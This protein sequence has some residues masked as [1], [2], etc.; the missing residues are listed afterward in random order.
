MHNLRTAVAA[1][2]GKEP[3]DPLVLAVL[4]PAQPT[5]DQA[6]DRARGN[7]LLVEEMLARASVLLDRCIRFKTSADDLSAAMIQNS[8]QY[9]YQTSLDEIDQ[10]EIS[11]ELHRVEQHKTEQ[12]L[13]GLTTA[14]SL[15]TEALEFLK[16]QKRVLDE[17]YHIALGAPALLRRLESGV[18]GALP[19]TEAQ[20][21]QYDEIA[22]KAE[23][24]EIEFRRSQCDID[25]RLS[26]AAREMERCEVQ[27]ATA[28]VAAETTRADHFERR[29]EALRKMLSARHTHSQGGGPLDFMA[30]A[31]AMRSHLQADWDGA[32]GCLL[33]A[34]EGLERVYG[35]REPLP[36]LSAA[37]NLAD[38]VLWCQRRIHD[39]G[40]LTSWDVVIT[41][42]LR[43][44][45]IV[46]DFADF[47]VGSKCGFSLESIDGFGMERLRGL[48]VAQERDDAKHAALAV[49][50][51]APTSAHQMRAG[52]PNAT[53]E[54]PAPTVSEG[55]CLPS[56]LGSRDVAQDG[57]APIVVSL[58]P[59]AEVASADD[60]SATPAYNACPIGEWTIELVNSDGAGLT[61]LLIDLQIAVVPL[62]A[63]Q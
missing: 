43:V 56:R 17:G 11:K 15:T 54:G 53:H 47:E 62:R 29:G 13:A 49:K 16:R 31:V 9:D 32:L 38:A 4:T 10:D 52:L 37:T 28:S 50:L 18:A 51:T 27:M 12:S 26:E 33:A 30:R 1:W 2:A 39:L 24:V 25:L 19:M 55:L 59:L 5:A 57:L 58:V 21:T 42:R 20:L 34:Q 45:E 35:I 8:I 41:R 14:L 22:S 48:R 7:P 46:H 60:F 6:T 3:D 63:A 40:L 23:N 61:D 36:D 44:S